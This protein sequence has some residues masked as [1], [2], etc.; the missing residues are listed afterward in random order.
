MSSNQE[1]ILQKYG[2]GTKENRRFEKSRSSGLEFHYTKR[3]LEGF[4]TEADRVLEIGCA[5][6]Y[7]GMY[8]ADKCRE[9]VGIDIVPGHIGIFQSKIDA[10]RL[11]NVSCRV[12]DATNLSEIP[13]GSFDVVLCLGPIYHLPPAEQ[14]KVM[15]EC[16]RV[17]CDGG[18]VAIAYLNSVGEYAGCCV[19]DE[20]RAHYPN[21]RANELVLKQFMDDVHE[22]VFFFTMPERIEAQAAEYGLTK[23]RNLGTHFTMMM[24]V[25][26]GMTD[27]QF[28]LLEPLYDQMTSH[29][30]CTGMSNHA[31][32]IC[33]KESV[34]RGI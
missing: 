18:V 22:N 23:I 27:E 16:G 30:S 2:D 17:C 10:A 11:K 24:S 20:W 25:V 12:G 14:D 1:M 31:L 8:Y 4:I 33:R 5:T 9:Y 32:L 19:H 28:A 26:N 29:E 7:Y 13:N 21:E 3:H 34:N 15:A 6:G